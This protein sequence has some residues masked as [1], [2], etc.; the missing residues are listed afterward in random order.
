MSKVY[1]ITKGEYS[2][3]RIVGIFDDKYQAEKYHAKHNIGTYGGVND[4][5]EYELNELH[6][7]DDP[8]Y[9]IRCS[10]DGYI[11]IDDIDNYNPKDEQRISWDYN[12][13]E[14]YM[15]ITLQA[16][17]PEHAIKSANERRAMSIANGDWDD[18]KQEEDPFE[19]YRIKKDMELIKGSQISDIEI[20]GKIE[21]F[22][23][24]FNGGKDS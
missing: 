3:Y 8:Y 15:Y 22:V 16:K 11:K 20:A 18:I 14:P 24:Y 12:D 5:E 19:K 13:R 7:S 9:E 6:Q 2:D 1:V 17:S 4:I 21:E 10:K 23:P